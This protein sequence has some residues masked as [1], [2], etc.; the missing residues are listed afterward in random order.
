MTDLPKRFVLTGF[1]SGEVLLISGSV[2]MLKS[3][4]VQLRMEVNTRTESRLLGSNSML[5]AVF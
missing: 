3:S 5:V 2:G 1:A 4:L